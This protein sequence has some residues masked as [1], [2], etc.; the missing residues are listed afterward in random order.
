MGA[1]KT[2]V[3]NHRKVESMRKLTQACKLAI[4]AGKYKVVFLNSTKKPL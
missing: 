4:K 3:T 2:I 1:R